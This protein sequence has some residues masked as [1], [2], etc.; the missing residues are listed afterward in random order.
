M[1]DPSKAL[2]AFLLALAS[3]SLLVACGGDDNFDDR[4]DTA[5]PKVRFVHAF[6]G[7]PAVTLQRGGVPEAAATNVDYK[8]ASQYYGVPTTFANFSLRAAATNTE[9]A[10]ASIDAQR[11][12]KYTLVAM[13]ATGAAELLVINDPYHKR[14]TSND[15]RLR[16]INAAPN[17]QT[18]DVYLTA[19]GIDL[20]TVLPGITD[21][22]Y[23]KVAPASGE[24]SI[25]IS[26]G[27]YQL[28]I[29]PQGS[30]KVIFNTLVSV[31]DNADWLLVVLQDDVAAP[32]TNAVRMLLVRS[33]DSA[34][35]T[36]EL[37]TQP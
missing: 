21:L 8:Y 17:A 34:D 32:T 36:D 30:K 31:P 33:D 24:D 27:T 1:N 19:V 4:A 28:R 11:G 23:K 29:T 37:L 14:L 12:T 3:T 2:R 18:F 7:G 13:P 26:D 20:S 9:V 5:D 6:P 25:E 10:T 35:A 15:A 16:V 22:A